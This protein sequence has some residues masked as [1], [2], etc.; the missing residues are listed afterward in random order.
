M[1]GNY[2]VPSINK[3]F[4]RVEYYKGYIDH[5]DHDIRHYSENLIEQLKKN[6]IVGKNDPVPIKGSILAISDLTGETD[7]G[8]R[9]IYPLLTEGY[10]VSSKDYVLK[11]QDL[12]QTV[13]SILFSQSYEALETYFKDI[14]TLYFKH[15]NQIAFETIG[16]IKC[17]EENNQIDWE[18]TVRKL[19]SGSNNSEFLNIFRILSSEFSDSEK[20]NN[21]DIDLAKWYNVIS[22]SR[23]AITHSNSVLSNDEYNSL[24]KDGRNILSQFFDL[25]LGIEKNKKI[26]LSSKHAIELLELICEYGFL[27][28]KCLS[29][30]NNLDWK[31]LVNMKKTQTEN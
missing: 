10:W 5:L 19:K 22:I 28:F 1:Q 21:M 30:T 14:L 25:E 29:R 3:L 11:N 6:K 2:L 13:S 17:I 15:N 24:D 27:I 26:K 7:N 8:W 20:N 31:I 16:K 9:I 4:G 12:I 23:H 18:K